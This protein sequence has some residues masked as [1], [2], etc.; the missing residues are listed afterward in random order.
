M[1]DLYL[2]D[3]N[4]LKKIDTY[5]FWYAQMSNERKKK[6][7][8]FVFEKDRMLSLG[9]GILLHKGLTDAGLKETNYIYGQYGKPYLQN[10]KLFFNI[11]HSGEYV[12]CGFSDE[13][14]GVDIEKIQT[15]DNELINFVFNKNEIEY[16]KV[17][18]PMPDE[19]F[20]FLW[21][22]KE[23]VMKYFGTG[24]SLG[25]KEI[26]VDMSGEISATCK[27]YNCSELCF[28]HYPVKGYALTVCSNNKNISMKTVSL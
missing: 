20:T 12:V 28:G 8:S 22:I 1:N 21:T 13:E 15:F 5:M 3:I 23:S 24:L 16:I 4:D 19:G 6:I 17:N 7:D 27:K 25:P 2:L 10:E 11:S 9:A 14:I 26:D 18:Y